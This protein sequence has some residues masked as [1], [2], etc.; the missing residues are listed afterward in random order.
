MDAENI[1]TVYDALKSSIEGMLAAEAERGDLKKS[2][3]DDLVGKTNIYIEIEGALTGH[4]Y[5][6]LTKATVLNIVKEM[7]G[8]EVDEVNDFAKS[9]ISEFANLMVSKSST[10][11]LNQDIKIS[12]SPPEVIIEA[13]EGEIDFFGE[14][15]IAIPVETD[16]GEMELH[17]FLQ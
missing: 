17:V 16:L 9:A 15:F 10:A 7:A 13:S 5:L 8:M 14:T 6:S 2:Q 3:S 11:F 12:S 1:N 4:I